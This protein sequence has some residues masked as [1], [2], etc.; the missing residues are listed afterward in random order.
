MPRS[1]LPYFSLILIL[2]LAGCSSSRFTGFS[3]DP[4]GVTVTTDKEITPQHRRT[5]GISE[6]GLWL[7]NE[8]SGARMNDFYKINDSLYQ[9][10]LEPENH[11]INNSTWYSF[12]IRA[13]T[14]KTIN[15]KLTYVHGEHRY[16]P[17]LSRDGRNWTSID[18]T[19]FREDTLN[20]TA[21]LK[22]EVS[23]DPLWVSA[24]ELLTEEDYAAWADSLAE[25][26]FI[27]RDT[28]GYSHQNRPIRKITID[29]ITDRT[30]RGVLIITGRLHPPE[31]T[32]ALA[33]LIFIEELASNS[34]LANRFRQ[35]FEVLAFPFANPD[36]VQNGHWRHNA[37]GIDLNRDWKDFNQPETRAIRDDLLATVKADSSKKV[38]Y[39][40]DFHS[41]NENIFYPIN[42]EI[43][44]F[45][46]DFTYL[47]VDSLIATFPDTEFEVEPFD[48]SSPI[49]KNWIYRTFG[50]DAVTYEV[51][52]SADREKLKAIA[53]KSAQIIMELLL[54]EMEK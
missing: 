6:D 54:E 28:V 25:K 26:P 53:R 44:T 17:E 49:T 15:L 41:T 52:D 39:G 18:S 19:S 2:L 23:P 12:K 34:D 24:Q 8:F 38:F 9:V 20:G 37:G 27:R 5:I 29:E 11:P 42:R 14:V 16:Y 35:Y 45:P 21:T 30:N 43:K 7:T 46:D 3:Y 1:F 33:S 32:G 50:A 47:W 48:T 13:D 4:E 51:D 40:I 10:V 31:V 36:G 22:L